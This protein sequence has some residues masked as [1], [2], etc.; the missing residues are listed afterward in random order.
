MRSK[1]VLI[2]VGLI[3]ILA[4]LSGCAKA[5]QEVVDA[6]NAALQAAE[7]AQAN[8]Y[9]P[10]LYNAAKDSLNAAMEEVNAQGSKFALTRNYDRAKVLLESAIAA[11]NAAK[12]GVAA[13]KEEVK[14]EAQSLAAQAQTAV[15]ETKNL[16]A[17]APKGKEGKEVLEQMQ[18]ELSGAETAITEATSAMDSGDFIGARD[19]LKAALEKA[20]SLNQELADAISKKSMLSKKM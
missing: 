9:V 20:N 17:K 12:D 13:K 1:M 2:S 18:A 7:E 14:A 5:P 19:K 6:A 8:L 10:D 3:F 16:L 4:L 11:A 15:E